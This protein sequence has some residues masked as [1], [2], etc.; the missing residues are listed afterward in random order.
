MTYFLNL[1]LLQFLHEIYF[2]ILFSLDML[3]KVWN[4]FLNL[5]YISI[6]QFTHPVRDFNISRA[7][8]MLSYNYRKLIP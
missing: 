7:I 6:L 1:F 3:F 4:I 8:N 2:H 5:D